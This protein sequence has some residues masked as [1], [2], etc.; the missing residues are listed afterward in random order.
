[1]VNTG[2]DEI[3][4]VFGDIRDETIYPL[5]SMLIELG[6]DAESI[7]TWFNEPNR[8]LYGKTPLEEIYARHFQ[9]VVYAVRV[10]R[11]GSFGLNPTDDRDKK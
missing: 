7:R 11:E 10:L 5:S 9:D 6:M 8:Y 1:M 3:P 4:V 2:W